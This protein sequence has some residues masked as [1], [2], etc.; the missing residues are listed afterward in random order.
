MMEVGC[1]N[2]S[3]V[4]PLL[5][6]QEERNCCVPVKFYAF[7]FAPSAIEV[8]KVRAPLAMRMNC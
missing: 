4:F 8:V 6:L 1:G 2:G 3:T 7:D 5:A